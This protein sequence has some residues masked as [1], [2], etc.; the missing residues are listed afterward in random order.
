MPETGAMALP[1]F[2]NMTLQVH[3]HRKGGPSQT[4]G[5]DLSPI[6]IC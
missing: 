4:Q 5:E 3:V 2:F 6:N 1:D